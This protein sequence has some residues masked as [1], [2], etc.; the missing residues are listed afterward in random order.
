MTSLAMY[1][2][3]SGS[4]KNAVTLIRMVLNS[5]EN[6]S[7][8]ACKQVEILFERLMIDL[9]HSV[10]NPSHQRG[11]FVAGEIESPRIAH[12]TQQGFE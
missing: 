10:A 5:A 6:S 8:L 7:E 9:G 2:H 1:C 11:A 4:R 12:E 3:A